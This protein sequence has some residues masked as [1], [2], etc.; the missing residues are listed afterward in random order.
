VVGYPTAGAAPKPR[1]A[2]DASRLIV[3]R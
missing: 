3:E 1:P 2:P